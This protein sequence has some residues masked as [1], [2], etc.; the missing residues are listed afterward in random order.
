MLVLKGPA[1]DAA[2]KELLSGL[3]PHKVAS[4]IGD[5]AVLLCW[6]GKAVDCHRGAV[7]AWLRG[8]GYDVEEIS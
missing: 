5:G 7:A 1:F 8:A 4:E 2:Y 3:D 6:E